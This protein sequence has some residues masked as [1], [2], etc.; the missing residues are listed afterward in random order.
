MAILIWLVVYTY[1]SEK[2]WSSSVGMMKFPT[3]WK[4]IKN[5]PNHQPVIDLEFFVILIAK[6]SQESKTLTQILDPQLILDNRKWWIFSWWDTRNDY[7]EISWDILIYIY[8]FPKMGGTPSKSS[9]F[10]GLNPSW[11]RHLRFGTWV[12]TIQ[13]SSGLDTEFLRC[14][15]YGTNFMGIL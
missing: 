15:D 10:I 12:E 5:V 2:W 6:A 4:V 13:C 7:H 14:T 11:P 9:I 8:R 1:P 3:E